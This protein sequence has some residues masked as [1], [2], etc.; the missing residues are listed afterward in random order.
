VV[1]LATVS[2]FLIAMTIALTLWAASPVRR[3]RR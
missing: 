1:L 2:V 3:R